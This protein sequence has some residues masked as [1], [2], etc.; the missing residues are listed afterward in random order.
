MKIILIVIATTL[1]GCSASVTQ[2]PDLDRVLT[3]AEFVAQ[4][5]LRARVF[6]YC[7]NNP[8]Q[9][10][11]DPNCINAQ[12]AEHIASIGTGHFRFVPPGG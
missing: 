10:A 3:V 4:A 2:V 6:A 12:Q 9:T 11:L 5:P 7:A 1:A 8:G